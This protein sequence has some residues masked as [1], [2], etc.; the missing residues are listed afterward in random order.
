MVGESYSK[1]LLKLPL[2]D[3]TVERRILDTSEGLHDQLTDQLKTLCS[4]LQVN[5]VT[6]VVR[7]KHIIIYV[8][9]LLENCVKVDFLFCRPTDGKSYVT[10]NVQYN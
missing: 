6:D 3:N 5:E 1:E 7:D 4:A 2:A 8:C 10:R 9:Y